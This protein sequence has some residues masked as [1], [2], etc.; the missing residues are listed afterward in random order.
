MIA[1]LEP[2]QS[3]ESGPTSLT[4]RCRAKRIELTLQFSGNSARG[5]TK[6]YSQIDDQP[7]TLL[8]WSWSAD[9][10]IATFKDDPMSFLQALP[11]GS[12]LWV[13]TGDR[14]RESSAFR[15]VGL[16]GIRRKVAAA[17]NWDPQQAETSS[18]KNR[19]SR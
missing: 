19:I 10:R 1:V 5:E 18:R 14:A 17:C 4:I 13:W 8:D 7:S 12:T 3:R 6:L 16:D 9:G 2:A 15:L 11:E